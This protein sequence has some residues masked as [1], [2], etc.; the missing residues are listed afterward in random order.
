MSGASY[1]VEIRASK[2]RPATAIA[3]VFWASVAAGLDALVAE[4]AAR[5]VAD[6][7]VV[8][9]LDRLGDGLR[10]GARRRRGGARARGASRVAGVP[11]GAGGPNRAGSAPY[12]AI[13][14]ATPGARATG[15]PTSRAAP[16]RACRLWRTRS[17]SV[18]TSMPGLDPARAGRH[19]HPRALDLDD[20]DA[21][22]VD[23]GQA[24]EVA[25]RRDVDPLGAAGVEDR[26][27][28]RDGDRPAVEGDLDGR[29]RTTAGATGMAVGRAG[30]S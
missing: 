10:D 24:L 29:R 28:G 4:D 21:A 2:P 14:A 12:S 11:A 19:E 27:A 16:A 3:K 1:S 9:D 20:A 22:D 7:E 18:C 6:V 17:E 13:I 8:V 23:R 5:V 26:R 25:E 30:G 15:R